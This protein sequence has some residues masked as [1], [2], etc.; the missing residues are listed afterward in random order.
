MRSFVKYIDH[1]SEWTGRIVKWLIFAL[2]GALVYEV[3]ARY[4]FVH[5][6][7]WSYDTSY[8]LY[9]SLF[10]LGA[11]YTLLVGGHVRIDVFYTRFSPRGRAIIDLV[12]YSVFFFPV[13]ALLLNGGIDFA[14]SSWEIGERSAV[15][16]WKL[17]IYPYKTVL[18]VA[19]LLLLIQGVAEFIRNLV[20]V[21]RKVQL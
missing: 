1:I 10:L 9:G 21:V 11:A 20:M 2:I 18:P 19:I 7:A 3:I 12:C 5:P 13:M 4:A 16:A 14:Q 17:P 6:T 8:I 15:S